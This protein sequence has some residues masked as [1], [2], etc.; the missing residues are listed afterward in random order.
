MMDKM[1]EIETNPDSKEAQEYYQKLREMDKLNPKNKRKPASVIIKNMRGG[2]TMSTESIEQNEDGTP[3][4][5]EEIEA[6]RRTIDYA[7]QTF[8][9]VNPVE[10]LVPGP[11]GSGQLR[12]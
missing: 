12:L 8:P 10:L 2:R 9:E 11:K 6:K 5:P 4:S 7:S 3:M 1:I